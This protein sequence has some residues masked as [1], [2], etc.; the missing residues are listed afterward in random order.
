M[1]RGRR[2]ES[3]GAGRREALQQSVV[4]PGA[5][6]G[7]I[8]RDGQFVSTSIGRLA[9]CARNARLRP[10][11]KNGTLRPESIS[12][13]AGM[14]MHASGKKATFGELAD[15]AAR[16]AVPQNVKPKDAKELRVHR[17][18]VRASR[19]QGESDREP[20]RSRKTSSCPTC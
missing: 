20:Q 18:I 7:R 17:Q 16:V 9:P 11:Q 15:A 8:D 4:G 12:V 13:K 5:G 14:I 10:L 19:Q 3:K 1:P 6:N 2:C